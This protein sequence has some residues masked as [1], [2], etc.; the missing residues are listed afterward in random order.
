M[1]EIFITILAI[2][3][4]TIV[5]WIFNKISPYKVCPICAGVSGTWFFILIAIYLGWLSREP[6]IIIAAIAMGGSVVG[7]AYQGEKKYPWAAK[8]IFIFK[9]PVITVGL[10]LVYWAIQNISLTAIIIE[11]IMLAMVFYFY[12]ILPDVTAQSIKDSKKVEELE[13]KM[14]S[15]C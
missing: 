1:L 9:V 7:I 2:L 4:I 11:V 3:A 8:N 13:D 5:I 14:K 12:F 15:C 10:I 6:W